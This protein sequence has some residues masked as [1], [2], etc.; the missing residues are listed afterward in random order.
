[1][2]KS[3]TAGTHFNARVVECRLAAKVCLT[4]R[5]AN[6]HRRERRTEIS[7]FFACY[8]SHHSHMCSPLLCSLSERLE[9]ANLNRTYDAGKKV[10]KMITL[11]ASLLLSVTWIRRS[12]N[13]DPICARRYPWGSYEILSL[14]SRP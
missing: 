13:L 9:Q 10:Q 1:M 2:K 7:P 3:A 12:G 6:K 11:D 5:R 14:G 8:S 4:E